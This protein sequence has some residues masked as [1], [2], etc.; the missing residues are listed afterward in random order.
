[1]TLIVWK[2]KESFKT[3][4]HAREMEVMVRIRNVLLKLLYVDTWSLADRAVWGAYGD[5]V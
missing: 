3:N 5:G 2:S 4:E 1:M